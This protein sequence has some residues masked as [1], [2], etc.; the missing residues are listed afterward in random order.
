[1]MKT[2]L[3][4]IA[5]IQLT[6]MMM[7]RVYTSDRPNSINNQPTNQLTNKIDDLSFGLMMVEYVG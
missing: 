6:M 3:I 4:N 7:V 5:N 2:T 1:M